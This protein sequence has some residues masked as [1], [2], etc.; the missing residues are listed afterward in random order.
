MGEQ[1]W[2]YGAPEQKEAVAR[3]PLAIC[4][5]VAADKWQQSKMDEVRNPKWQFSLYS[6]IITASVLSIL[7]ASLRA[8][9]LQTAVLFSLSSCCLLSLIGMVAGMGVCCVRAATVFEKSNGT[10]SPDPDPSGTSSE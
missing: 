5:G 1:V 3:E 8:V 2:P 9:G 4:F 10:S 6:L 7:M